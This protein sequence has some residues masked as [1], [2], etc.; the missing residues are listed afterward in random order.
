MFSLEGPASRRRGLSSK[1]SSVW[2]VGKQ[3]LLLPSELGNAQTPTMLV[4]SKYVYC[5]FLHRIRATSH[6]YCW[7]SHWVPG[8]ELAGSRG[9]W[10]RGSSLDSL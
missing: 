9:E 7:I 5:L 8:P 3:E 10:S 2:Q 4:G 1:N 6:L